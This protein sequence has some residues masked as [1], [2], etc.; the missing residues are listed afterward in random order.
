[1]TKIKAGTLD[2]EN[3][4]N[5]KLIKAVAL[6]DPEFPLKKINLNDDDNKKDV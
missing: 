4:D 6:A 5:K 3:E 2:L 1:M